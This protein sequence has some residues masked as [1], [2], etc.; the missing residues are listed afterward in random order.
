MVPLQELEMRM[1]KFRRKM[2]ITAPDWEI[3]II[4]KKINIYYFTGTMQEGMLII[5][6]DEEATY[7]VRRSFERA[8]DESPFKNIKPMNSFRDASGSL[9]KL[10]KTVYLET[11]VVPLALYERFRKYFPFENVKPCDT[12]IAE[13]RAVKSPYELAL[14]E[15]S[16]QIHRKVLEE[17]VPGLLKEGM[18]EL[19]LAIKIFEKL[20]EEGHHGVCRF[21]MFDTEM[22]V[23]QIGFGES[24]IYPTYFN[25]P[26]GNYGMS[27]VV[28]FWGSRERKLKKGDLVFVDMGCGYEGYHTDKTMIYLFGK[29]LPPDVIDVHKKCVEIQ[30]EIA[31]LLK[32]GEIPANIY[33]KIMNNLEP[34]FLENF[35]GFGNRKVKFLGHGIG[36]LIDELPVIANGFTEPLQENMVFAVEPKKGIK[37]IGMVGIENTFVVTSKGGK[38]IT[39]E[40][41]DYCSGLIF[42]E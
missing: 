3:A 37:D 20:L 26:G 17:D 34:D 11:E 33:N 29:S 12:Q 10:P 4:F 5:P 39:G 24:S 21:G 13:V 36:L 7:W 22:G 25:G 27:P 8:L 30:N 15:R 40:Y 9:K 38:N 1:T 23:G 16:G 31:S 18:S 42:V 6:R 14:M 2:D 19:E 41:S 32:P 35:M 28:P